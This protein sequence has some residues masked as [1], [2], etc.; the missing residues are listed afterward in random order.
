MPDSPTWFQNS[1][2]DRTLL[3]TAFNETANFLSRAR[4]DPTKENIE[5]AA[6]AFNKAELRYL[7]MYNA[8]RKM[9]TG[10]DELVAALKTSRAQVAAMQEELAR[11]AALIAPPFV[12]GIY[13]SP[14]DDD[15]VNVFIHGRESRVG[16][17]PKLKD[18]L[19]P[20]HR[21]ALVGGSDAVIGIDGFGTL[22]EV[23][24]VKELLDE[25]RI[26]VTLRADEERVCV[27]AE[28]L[29]G[30]AVKV[31]DHLR[32]DGVGFVYEVIPKHEIGEVFL[33]EVPDVSY[34]DIGGLDEQI[35]ALRDAV[36]LPWLHADLFRKYNQKSPKGVLLYGPPGCGKTMVAKAVANDLAKRVSEKK[37]EPVKGF[38]LNIKGPELLNKYVG[39]TERKIREVFEKAREKASEDVPVVVF[40]DEMESL[41]R[42]RG[43]GISSDIETTIVPTILS[44]IDGVEGLRNVIVIGASN[45]QDLIDP[46]VLRS[47][48]LDVK[49]EIK[50][51]GARGAMDILNKYARPQLPLHP[52]FG[53]YP[54]RYETPNRLKT[55]A[56]AEWQTLDATLAAVREAYGMR[57][58]D[59]GKRTIPVDEEKV[60]SAKELAEAIADASERKRVI[61]D[62]DRTEWEFEAWEIRSEE[63]VF[64]YMNYK[65]VEVIFLPTPGSLV[66]VSSGGEIVEVD[67]RFLEVTYANA[68]KEVLYHK[69]FVSGAMLESIV[70]RAKKYAI[71]RAINDPTT[72]LMMVDFWQAT[73]EEFKENEDLPNTANPDDWARIQGKK[74]ERIAFV[75]PIA[76]GKLMRAPAG[77]NPARPVEQVVNTGQYL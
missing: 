15:L 28:P 2:N 59:L 65:A 46:A 36:E 53:P 66:W 76:S 32:M 61:R 22:G 21:V 74:G 7:E 45:R 40:F 20:G 52:K 50:R 18:A 25:D 1:E 57:R 26:L 39:E 30:T 35:E 70:R 19:R 56:H 13:R 42:T 4:Q 67:T 73:R 5:R 24:S 44:E 11:L 72:G 63:D 49:I 69:D 34:N 60:E 58:I 38:F 64:H 16:V 77:A 10:N 54:Q 6:A 17:D 51:P 12:Y 23:G 62:L 33:E 8:A 14:S 29:R 43:T 68:D 9:K 3:A 37:G 41:F 48:R 75:R 71:K 27:R 55:L 47:G 31:G